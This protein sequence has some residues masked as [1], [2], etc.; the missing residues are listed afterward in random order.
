[1]EIQYRRN[2]E[3]SYMILIEPDSGQVQEMELGEQMCRQKVPGLLDWVSMKNGT[4]MTFWYNITSY[5]SV[6]EEMT[7][8]S[9][10]A[11]FFE[12]LL[13]Q[14]LQLN[15]NLVR[16]YLKE[17]HLM[18]QPDLIYVN[19]KT[20][21]FMFCYNP[22][23]KKDIRQQLQKLLEA[24][25]VELN[26]QEKKAVVLGYG[27]YEKVLEENGSIWELLKELSVH[28]LQ[29][30]DSAE[31]TET[32]DATAE[33]STDT[34]VVQTSEN[35]ELKLESRFKWTVI[36]EPLWS[37]IIDS[38]KQRIHMKKWFFQKE[39]R[40]IQVNPAY[41]FC[42][43][44][45]QQPIN[46]PTEVLCKSA[47]P[48]GVLEYTGHDGEQDIYIEEKEIIIGGNNQAADVNLKSATV[49]HIHARVMKE[50]NTYTLEDLN[51]KNGTLHNGSLLSYREKQELR[52]GDRI[53]FA[54]VTYR[55]R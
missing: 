28:N 43:E 4:E 37:G 39:R 55:F 11:D 14:L 42:Q 40:E 47:A 13:R 36:P 41:V 26:H 23:A 34:A 45:E 25:L 10:G 46:H 5:Q 49:S 35:P 38:L 12:Q 29:T 9:L 18:L 52:P 21:E 1:M 31:Q 22:Y 15:Y 44:E 2:M 16:Y 48:Q 27:L 53:T 50:Q 3:H 54:G 7:R 19:S 51:S 20:H 30:S 6:E 8:K 33:Q 24:L 32:K 17:E